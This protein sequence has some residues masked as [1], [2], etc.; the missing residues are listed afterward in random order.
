M[1]E[2]SVRTTAARN[3]TLIFNVGEII[4]TTVNLGTGDEVYY[5]RNSK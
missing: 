5:Y 2:F 4:R 1:V 3:Y